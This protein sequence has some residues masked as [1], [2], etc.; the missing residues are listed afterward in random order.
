MKYDA[1]Q[2]YTFSGLGSQAADDD[3]RK[4]DTYNMSHIAAP[5]QFI[6]V[7]D[8]GGPLTN[9]S[10]D[11]TKRKWRSWISPRK[12]GNYDDTTMGGAAAVRPLSGAHDGRA[13]VLY[14]DGHVKEYILTAFE[15]PYDQYN[16][17]NDTWFKLWSLENE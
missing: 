17:N 4:Y 6:L 15:P 10:S 14:A 9:A 8:S 3:D 2:P 7:A 13:N 12:T 11:K 5:G 16:T 1:G